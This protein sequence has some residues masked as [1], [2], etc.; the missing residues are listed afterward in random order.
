MCNRKTKLLEFRYAALS[1]FQAA[2][3]HEITFNTDLPPTTFQLA[4]LTN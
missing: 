4:I 1:F 3:R 2:T